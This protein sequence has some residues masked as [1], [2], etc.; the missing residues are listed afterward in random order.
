MFLAAS[1]IGAI[2]QTCKLLRLG[3][4]IAVV[5]KNDSRISY[6]LEQRGG[7]WELDSFGWHAQ[8]M[9]GCETCAQGQA[10]GGVMWMSTDIDAV[11]LP[12]AEEDAMFVSLTGSAWFAATGAK[13]VRLVDELK[14]EWSGLAMTVRRYAS[15]GAE[16]RIDQLALTATDG[17]LGIRFYLQSAAMPR[18]PLE[19]ALRP[20]LESFTIRRDSVRP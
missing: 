8:A 12:T 2:A 19:E 5:E 4:D 10:Q 16:D 1:G 18:L 15:E 7:Q 14:G 9:L 6:R 3:A 11:R 17:C 13:G 20:L